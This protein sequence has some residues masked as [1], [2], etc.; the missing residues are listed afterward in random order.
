MVVAH[1]MSVSRKS[2]PRL[3][4]ERPVAGSSSS[5][6]EGGVA[7]TGVIVKGVCE[8]QGL[9]KKTRHRAI[10]LSQRPSADSYSPSHVPQG[11]SE[12]TWS[13]MIFM[14]A[15][16][17]MASTRPMPPQS[18]PQNNN[19]IVTASGFSC[20]RLPRNLG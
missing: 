11:F 3:N 2:C 14:A 6:A 20:M 8:A 15:V 16:I 12:S 17:G 13:K 4:G 9:G 1:E 7:D 19:A 5:R 18:H 10:G